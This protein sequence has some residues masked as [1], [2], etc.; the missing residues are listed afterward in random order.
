M[1][2]NSF[3]LHKTS[4]QIQQSNSS[5]MSFRLGETNPCID[6]PKLSLTR[7]SRREGENESG[8]VPI[9]CNSHNIWHDQPPLEDHTALGQKFCFD[10]I[11][12]VGVRPWFSGAQK[13]AYVPALMGC[14][15]NPFAAPPTRRL[16]RLSASRSSD[17]M[18]P[19]HNP[20]G[21]PRKR[22]HPHRDVCSG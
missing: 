8:Q 6:P 2:C 14:S 10:G 7:L 16:A 13:P 19:L 15:C 4:F 12:H 21:R 3:V 17:R 9:G 11:G 20:T 22:T 5:D 1:F 18:G